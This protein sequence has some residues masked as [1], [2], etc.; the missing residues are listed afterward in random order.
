MTHQTVNA[1]LLHPSTIF[2]VLSVDAWHIN[3]SWI[4]KA[5]YFWYKW[6]A[7][8]S[9]MLVLWISIPV[10]QHVLFSCVHLCEHLKCDFFSR[11]IVVAEYL[12]I[13]QSG[14]VNLAW[15]ALHMG[16]THSTHRYKEHLFIDFRFIFFPF[17]MI[18]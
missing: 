4:T 15:C 7:I 10:S 12:P 16:I 17:F 5:N 18:C 8:F 9:I 2:T 11:K 13:F 1:L 14:L 3:N 6:T